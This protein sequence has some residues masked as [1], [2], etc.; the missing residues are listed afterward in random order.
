MKQ[1]SRIAAAAAL[2]AG[3]L[4]STSASAAIICNL[5]SYDS[6]TAG[7]N[8]LSLFVGSLNANNGDLSN[9]QAGASVNGFLGNFAH[10]YIFNFS[11][12]G[13]VSSSVTFTPSTEISN[14]TLQLFSAT[15]S[16]CSAVQSNPQPIGGVGTGGCS[17]WA[18]TGLLGTATTGPTNFVNLA[19]T[20][21]PTGTYLVRISGTSSLGLPN[22]TYNGAITTQNVPEPGSLALAGLALVGAAFAARRRKA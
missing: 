18:T 22:S 13:S 9:I 11:P 1:L 6:A 19:F 5:C 17:S 7:P 21:I 3:A 4:V 8:G 15:A 2:A 14:F 16:G 20:A 10:N 12:I